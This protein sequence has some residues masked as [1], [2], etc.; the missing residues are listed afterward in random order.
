MSYN[1]GGADD[2]C[3]GLSDGRSESAD[4]IEHLTRERDELLAIVR[5]GVE[6]RRD[7]ARY[8][9]LRT[10]FWLI[11]SKKSEKKFDDAALAMLLAPF[12]AATG[13]GDE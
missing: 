4:T 3:G 11:E 12:T 1:Q 6:M 9:K 7:Q 8:F 5:L 13:A 2:Y 10:Q